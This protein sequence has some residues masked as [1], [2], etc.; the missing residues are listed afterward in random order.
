M[1]ELGLNDG[2]LG[3]DDIIS[4]GV[5]TE[6]F[7]N[8]NQYNTRTM[9]YKSDDYLK[10]FSTNIRSCRRNFARL[11]AFLNC[12]NIAFHCIVLSEIWLTDDTDNSFDLQ[13]YN[14]FSTFRNNFGGGL[15]VYIS[16][17]IFA[18]KIEE[19]SLYHNIFESL[20]ISFVIGGSKYRFIKSS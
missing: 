4:T 10:I 3:V 5:D 7:D 16:N 13:G 2:D 17:N 20:C 6:V 9:N 14:S 1:A 15:K 12:L 18:T 11:Q 19:F 8:I